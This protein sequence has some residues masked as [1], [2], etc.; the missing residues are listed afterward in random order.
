M[1]L[2]FTVQKLSSE[3]LEVI[4]IVYEPE[5]PVY[6]T[7]FSALVMRKGISSDWLLV[8]G[9][10]SNSKSFP[11]AELRRINDDGML[12]VEICLK[13][14]DWWIDSYGL[15][16]I[17]ITPESGKVTFDVLRELGL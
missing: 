15:V 3:K 6:N 11:M 9:T 2:T 1:D 14:C 12:Q 13:G 10:S 17:G 4:S 8:Y 16:E 5:S 7:A